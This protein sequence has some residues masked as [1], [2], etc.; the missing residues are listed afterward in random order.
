M[1]L[2]RGFGHVQDLTAQLCPSPV[3]CHPPLAL[4]LP[5]TGRRGAWAEADLMA[6]LLTR[7]C[8]TA[9]ASG[10]SWWYFQH[11]QGQDHPLGWVSAG[12]GAAEPGPWAGTRGAAGTDPPS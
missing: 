8:R 1:Q 7:G 4:P 9:M 5:G 3:T 12:G 11:C 10:S 2:C 6:A